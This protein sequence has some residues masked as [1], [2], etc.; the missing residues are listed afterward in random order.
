MESHNPQ[1]TRPDNI[2]S[3]LAQ[4]DAR[5]A[6][7]ETA[8]GVALS[9]ARVVLLGDSWLAPPDQLQL[10]AARLAADCNAA[11]FAAHVD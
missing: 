7:L 5:I 1:P 9:R 11:V 4:K 10:V 8:L 2:K 6:E 3:L